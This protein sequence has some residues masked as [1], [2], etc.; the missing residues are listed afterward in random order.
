MA[1][2]NTYNEIRWGSFSEAQ[3]TMERHG[4]IDADGYGKF[5]IM[6]NTTASI[7]PSNWYR[8]VYSGGKVTVTLHWTDIYQIEKRHTVGDEFPHS[9]ITLKSGG[10]RTVTTKKRINSFLPW[11][12]RIVQRDFNWILQAM[13]EGTFRD[14]ELYFDGMEIKIPIA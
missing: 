1:T 7:E 14:Q 3:K 4:K 12:Y 2:Y 13:E 10:Y 5:K 6:H 11:N 8:T 9:V